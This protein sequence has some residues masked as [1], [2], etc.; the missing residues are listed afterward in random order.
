MLMKRRELRKSEMTPMIDMIF[1]L[2]I[3]FLVTL[4]VDVQQSVK[5]GEVAAKAKEIS[6]PASDDYINADRIVFKDKYKSNK[7]FTNINANNIQLA[8]QLLQSKQNIYS[9]RDVFS[10]INN[11]LV[12]DKY[13]LS[14]QIKRGDI[15]V[16][17][18]DTMEPFGNL[19]DVYDLIIRQYAVCKWTDKN[20]YTINSIPMKTVN[21]YQPIY[22]TD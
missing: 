6:E 18:G 9:Y 11:P 15:V 3:F 20:I 7:S 19:F 2:L 13:E 12:V 17:G 14:A 1:L 4:S 16:L 22:L 10:N 5:G 8:N 21:T